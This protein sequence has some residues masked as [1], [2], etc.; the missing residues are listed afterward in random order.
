ME[1]TSLINAIT[2]GDGLQ[3]AVGVTLLNKVQDTQAA[4]SAVMLQDFAAAQPQAPHPVLGKTLDI[5]I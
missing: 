3:Q 1:V 4:E 5:K 2:G